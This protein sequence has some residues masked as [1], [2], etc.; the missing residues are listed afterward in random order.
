MPTVVTLPACLMDCYKV[1]YPNL[2]FSRVAFY[3][4]LPAALALS[5]PAGFTMASGA[6]I[7]DIRVYI[8]DYKPCDEETFLTIAHE[9]VHVIQIQ[10]M[11]GG[12]WIPGSWT[13][14]YTSHFLCGKFWSTCAN[15]LEKE[16]YDFA[17]G[18][19]QA[20]CGTDGKLRD[21][22]DMTLSDAPCNCRAGWPV[23]NS[24]GAQ[25]YAEALGADPDLIKTSSS[26][27]RAW[28]SL[29]NWPVDLIFAAFS[30]FGF[31]NTGGAIGA[32]LGTVIGTVIGWIVGAAICGWPCGIVGGIVGGIIGGA[33]GWAINGIVNWFGGLF[34]GGA[35]WIWFTAFDGTRDAG[36]PRGPPGGHSKT[37]AGPA[38]AVYNGKLYL[39]YKGNGSN[40]LWYND[41]VFDGTSWLANDLEITQGGHSK[42]D[43]GPALAVYNGKLYLAY[44]GN[45]SNDLWYNVFDGT[46]WMA[47]DLE[48]TQGGHSKTDAGPALAMYNGKLYLAYKGNGSNDLWYNVFDGTS[49]M[50][51]DLEITQGGHSKTDAGPA[52][53]VYNGKLY[54]AYKGNGSND[55]WYNVFDGNS[56]LA[57]DLEISQNGHSQTSRR[58]ALAVYGG[59]LYLAY[60]G[61]GS[62]DIWYNVF[63]GNSWLAQDISV[64]QGG[65]VQ[66]AEGPALAAF[67]QYL[68]MTYRD[69]S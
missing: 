13:A 48:I 66:T 39:A 49:W 65:V 8:Q 31:S 14:Y 57:N 33:I 34:S 18:G 42:T 30:I 67:G 46:S 32:A 63:D 51:N 21:Y 20:N 54:L 22:V 53:A 40:D 28:C 44:K 10:G 43:A 5:A 17:N 3:S 6:A 68:F 35:A 60:R 56:W 59:Q 1:L 58:P 2:D 36:R 64:T 69:N 52:L 27:G 4:G 62:D 50:A 15:E 47:N 38:L 37:D 29:L 24:I 12:G 41:N 23:A 25:T 9:L 55:L 11:H 7:P 19:A 16:A 45:G 61:G 26:V